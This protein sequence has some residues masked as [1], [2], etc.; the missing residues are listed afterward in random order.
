MR[1]QIKPAAYDIGYQYSNLTQLPNDMEALKQY[2]FELLNKFRTVW[3]E[4][5]YQEWCDIQRILHRNFT[6]R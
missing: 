2:S 4:V 1:T 3:N 6:K 5:E